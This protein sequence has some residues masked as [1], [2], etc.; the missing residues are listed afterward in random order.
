MTVGQRRGR[1]QNSYKDEFS[2]SPLPFERKHPWTK[3]A[4]P[5]R[6]GSYARFYLDDSH[7]SSP[8]HASVFLSNRTDKRGRAQQKL[9]ALSSP[10]QL[11]ALLRATSVHHTQFHLCGLHS[12]AWTLSRPLKGKSAAAGRGKLGSDARWR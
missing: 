10:N 1:E 12:Y 8:S 5:I 7:T 9:S 3:L 6:R 11:D 4:R 2:D